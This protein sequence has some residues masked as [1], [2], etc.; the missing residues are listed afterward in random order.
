MDL[1]M[2]SEVF[3]D[4]SYLIALSSSEDNL[5]DKA[6][7]LRERVKSERRRLVITRA[8]LL[9]IGNSLAKL[10]YRQQAVVLLSAFEA[11]ANIEIIP[12]SEDLY[13]RAFALYQARHDK[14]WGLVD[15][16]SFVVMQERRINDALTSDEHFRQ[17]GFR[18][19]LREDD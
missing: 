14:E 19:L 11:D 1:T 7:A 6:K 10:R 17:A 15:C 8:V 12:L 13:R 16:I 3:L 4:T 18:A 9:E 5:H 2:S